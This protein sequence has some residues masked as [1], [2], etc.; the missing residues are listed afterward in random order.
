MKAQ[1]RAWVQSAFAV[2][3]VGA[4]LS[5][6]A[7]PGSAFAATESSTKNN[8]DRSRGCD[9]VV[10]VSDVTTSGKVEVYGGFACPSNSGL[11]NQPEGATIRVKLFVNDQEILQSK[12][13][14]KTCKTVS[15]IKWT[16]HSDSHQ[17]AITD[18]SGTD[19]F[20]GEMQIV[21]FSGTVTLATPTIRS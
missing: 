5:A 10:S 19:R 2:G 18:D 11:W 17:V 14:L 7:L 20:R 21:S 8:W 16:C 3:L 13:A 15:G 1:K 12:K 9:A 6:V 4:V